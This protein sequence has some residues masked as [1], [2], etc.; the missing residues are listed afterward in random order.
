VDEGGQAVEL[1]NI[2]E[3][4]NEMI[5]LSKSVSLILMTFVLGGCEDAPGAPARED[6]AALRNNLKAC[7]GLTFEQAVRKLDLGKTDKTFFTDEP[8][9]VLRGM[10]Y[11]LPQKVEVTLYIAEQ[12]PLFRSFCDSREWDREQL[13]RARVGGI[14]Y[15]KGEIA[16]DVGPAVPWQWRRDRNGQ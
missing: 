11:Y 2:L 5:N 9:C 7:L 4:L 13:L 12:D 15:R 8:P 16:L 14:S 6:T 10:T 3:R 1:V